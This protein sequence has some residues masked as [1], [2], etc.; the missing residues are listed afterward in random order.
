[1]NII[2]TNP[3]ISEFLADYPKD[4]H[5]NCLLGIIL[6]GIYN[7]KTFS[8][9]F[10]DILTQIETK[11]PIAT[12]QSAIQA[13]INTKSP[14][15]HPQPQLEKPE[16]TPRFQ[17]SEIKPEK[18]SLSY[19]RFDNKPKTFINKEKRAPSK[20]YVLKNIGNMHMKTPSLVNPEVLT[21]YTS[22][23]NSEILRIADKFLNG[24]FVNE[25]CNTESKPGIPKLLISERSVQRS[26]SR[27]KLK[28]PSSSTSS[29]GGRRNSYSALSGEKSRRGDRTSSYSR[30]W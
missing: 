1:M 13:L 10:N 23:E 15:S 21:E 18:R 7:L 28:P 29:Q 2:L 8:I 19:Q 9:D 20:A 16:D 5:I 22:L 27:S 3:V 12:A 30:F 6:L 24:R 14:L 4:K 25:Y 26:E 17:P 11:Q